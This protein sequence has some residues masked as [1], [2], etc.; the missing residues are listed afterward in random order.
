MKFGSVPIAEAEGAICAHSQRLPG[1]TIKKGQFLLA[2]DIELLR[3]SGVNEVVVARLEAGDIHEDMAATQLAAVMAGE[4]IRTDKAFTG[5]V[6]MF[7][8]AAGILRVDPELIA[9]INRI[10]EAITVATLADY[11]R[12]DTGRMVATIKIIPYAVAET[13]L[14]E[15]MRLVSAV[16]RLIMVQPFRGMRVG[17]VS[18]LVDGLADKVIEKTRRTTLGRLEQMG[19]TL[20]SEIRCAHKTDEIGRAVRAQID[21]GHDLV[22]VFG[23]SATIDRRDMVPTGIEAAGGTIDH[24]GMPVD[25]GN[26][27]LLAHIGDV[28]VIGAPGCARSP[29]GNGFDWVL[30]RIAAG[31]A[32]G[33]G[34]ITA[35]GAGGLLMEIETRPQP[36][37]AKDKSMQLK[38]SRIGALVLAAGKSSRMGDANK[39]LQELDGEALVRHAAR[40]AVAC[41]A[42][43]VI[44]VTGHMADRVARALD[45]LDVGIALNPDFADGLSTSLRQ[46]IEALPDNIDGVLVLLG[47]MPRIKPELLKRMIAAFNPEAGRSIVV[48]VFDGKR[49]NPVLFARQY[50][51]E[52]KSVPG[53]IG[54]R[55][56]IAFHEG[57]VAEVVADASVFIDVDTPQAL[58]LLRT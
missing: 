32:V 13:A 57:A 28:Q 2:S 46:G 43:P 12:V 15:A 4:D 5:R 39:L 18:T 54:A 56:I 34:D 7:A 58:A 9:R 41:G 29:K 36:R 21:S 26:L 45:D 27:L 17:L 6:N 51:N 37:R 14:R 20:G 30:E 25:P 48:S 10:D 52:L 47:D 3:S 42:R 50:F 38:P 40:T 35:M 44:A 11:A 31:I 33:S 23:A 49:G 19:S 8:A 55:H 24:F 22:I 16:A 53:D 1:G